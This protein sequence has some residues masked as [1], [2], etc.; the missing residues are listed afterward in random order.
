MDLAYLLR[1]AAAAYPASV[2]VDDGQTTWSWGELIG[3]AERLAN[4][5]D[6]MGIPEGASVGIL[7]H[8]RA[9]Y[10]LAD[11]AI[12]LGRRVRVALNSRL[13]LDDFRY[14]AQ[15]ASLAA[16]FFSADFEEEATALA[17]ELGVIGIGFDPSGL[18]P[19]CAELIESAS[20]TSRLRADDPEGIAWISYTSGTT[21]RPK[22]VQLSHRAVR[23]VALNLLLELGPVIPGEQIVLPQPVSHGAGYF[24][25]PYLM[26]GA[27]VHVMRSFDPQ[28]VWEL[29]QR[30]QMRT[31][32]AVPAMLG[33]ILEAGSDRSEW[34]FETVVYGAS[35]ISA[36]L[37]EASLDRFGPTLIQDYGQS[38]APVTLTCLQRQD[39]LD[40]VARASAGRPWRSVAVEVRDDEGRV[41][42]PGEIGEVFVRGSHH[43]SGYLNRPEE[44][45]AVMVDGWIRTKDLGTTD[46]RGFVYL[47][48][49][50]DDMI[51]SGGFNV[52]PREVEDVV[53]EHPAVQE[54]AVLGTPDERWGSVVTA[55]VRLAPGAEA[56]PKEIID[57]SRPR[58]GIRA[59]KR[60]VVWPAIPRNGYGK[61]D[62]RAINE[63]LEME[64]S[65]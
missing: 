31:L 22:G 17:A 56:D 29:S 48:G 63:Q 25:L 28:R 46:D 38:E 33:P 18:G 55:V 41:V 27:G 23:E 54:V 50:R 35:G 9:S 42:A 34:G 36:P 6:E 57:F 65:S 26:S 7:S 64:E 10:V 47:R 30:K 32:K 5:L 51:V 19:P 59:P 61:V 11:V 8:N 21:G 43:M 13:H 4:A 1:R 62:R 45:A 24:V 12:A 49:R 53:A 2:A 3:L 15:D 16:L 40:P 39:H 44:T 14:A 52:A 37:L 20:G 60:V 58:L